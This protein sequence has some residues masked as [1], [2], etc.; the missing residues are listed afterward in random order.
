MRRFPTPQTE[1]SHW[2]D[3]QALNHHL[4]S[5]A[6]HAAN[7]PRVGVAAGG[8]A[9]RLP[10]HAAG[11]RTTSRSTAKANTIAAASVVVRGVSLAP[12]HQRSRRMRGRLVISSAA[13]DDNSRRIPIGEMKRALEQAVSS[14]LSVTSTPDPKNILTLYTFLKS[15]RIKNPKL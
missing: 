15:T 1:C 11:W 12:C 3:M 7:H 5:A 10:P 2:P 6:T 9:S 13:A 4:A 14:L 8:A